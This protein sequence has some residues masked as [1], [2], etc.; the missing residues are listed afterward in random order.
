L[1]YL[2]SYCEERDGLGR[3]EKGNRGETQKSL[4]RCLYSCELQL[5]DEVFLVLQDGPHEE[6]S[7]TEMNTWKPTGQ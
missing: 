7:P 2:I 4:H 1:R 3:R 6:G 5:L